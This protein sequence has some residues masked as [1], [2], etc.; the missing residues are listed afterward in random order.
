MNWRGERV[1][2]VQPPYARERQYRTCVRDDDGDIDG[3]PGHD[4]LGFVHL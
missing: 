2:Q 3:S 1:E 4:F